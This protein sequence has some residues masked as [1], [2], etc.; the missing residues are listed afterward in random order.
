[1][2]HVTVLLEEAV[3]ATVPLGRGR[4]VD[5]TAGGGGHAEAILDQ[6]PEVRLLAIDR[7]PEAVAR[8]RERLAKYGDRARVVQ[9]HYRDWRRLAQDNGWSEVDGI[10]LDLGFSSYQMDTPERGFSFQKQGPLD[11]RMNRSEGESA[12]DL[13][14]RLE[15]DEL[16]R[17]FRRYGEEPDAR[18]ISRAIVAARPIETTGA[19]ADIVASAV[20]PARRYGR[21]HPATL[22]FQA[23]RIAVNDELGE[24]ESFL[25][26]LPDGLAGGA[27]VAVISFHSLEDRMVKQTFRALGR[28]CV[29][30][31]DFP[32]C[33]C[34]N[35]PRMR[36][37]QRKTIRPGE[38]EIAQNP[39]AR[40]AK[41]RVAERIAA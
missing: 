31:P 12:A 35:L 4:I 7:D 3:N 25:A 41:L 37:I 6:G 2:S 34:G 9:G 38:E 14:N 16:A 5:G 15:A 11:M 30:P 1:M 18:R 19:L 26:D 21:I 20:A 23:L 10:L 33:R 27:R 32:V 22:V 24:L 36:E 40:S 29:C 8:V 13:V 28:G 17:L 39:R